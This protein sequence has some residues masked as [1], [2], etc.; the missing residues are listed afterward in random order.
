MAL[1]TMRE[2]ESLS[3][4]II[5]MVE[6]HNVL[7]VL[8]HGREPS[9]RRLKAVVAF[10]SDEFVGWVSCQTTRG[11]LL[12]NQTPVNRLNKPNSGWKG[13]RSK[14]KVIHH[15]VRA[16]LIH[17]KEQCAHPTMDDIEINMGL[18]MSSGS[19]WE[20]DRIASVTSPM[21]ADNNLPQRLQPGWEDERIALQE[22]RVRH[23]TLAPPM[24]S[25]TRLNFKQQKVEH[26]ETVECSI[27]LS[28]FACADTV[29][30]LPCRH[31][32]HAAC[33]DPWL[34]EQMGTGLRGCFPLCRSHVVM[35]DTFLTTA[36]D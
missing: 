36:G 28:G 7:R 34:Q 35:K 24:K 32:F 29:R 1:M 27:C 31:Q 13:W 2:T 11:E 20:D 12:L 15:K 19:S 4:E 8:D 17:H 33:V 10:E 6:A 3:S 16:S 14:W 22:R 5:A 23:S 9:S 21:E 30:H 26:V 18:H 25:S